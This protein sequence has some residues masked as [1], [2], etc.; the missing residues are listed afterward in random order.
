LERAA[1]Q[2]FCQ[3]AGNAAEPRTHARLTAAALDPRRLQEQLEHRES[4]EE[5]PGTRSSTPLAYRLWLAHLLWLEG[6]LHTLDCRPADISASELAGVQALSRARARFLR[7][8]QFCPRCGA[9][10]KSLLT[11]SSRCHH[12]HQPLSPDTEH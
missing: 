8:H 7:S 12:C 3:A 1:Y 4:P 2:L 5:V 10:N 6:I 9:A 11:A